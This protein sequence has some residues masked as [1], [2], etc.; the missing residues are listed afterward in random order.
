VCTESAS[1]GPPT[2]QLLQSF[3][4]LTNG[5][6]LLL[7]F[8]WLRARMFQAIGSETFRKNS[9]CVLGFGFLLIGLNTVAIPLDLEML[10]FQE[11]YGDSKSKLLRVDLE[12]GKVADAAN[13]AWE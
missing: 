4:I 5:C 11:G 12:S 6:P 13:E 1:G 8:V 7:L 9:T 2:F 3:G 10:G